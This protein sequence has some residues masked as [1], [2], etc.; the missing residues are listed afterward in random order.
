MTLISINSKKVDSYC[1]INDLIKPV[2]NDISCQD[3]VK[4]TRT[5]KG[6]KITSTDER[7]L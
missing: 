6:H 2:Y 3:I 1:C 5:H 4:M 7:N